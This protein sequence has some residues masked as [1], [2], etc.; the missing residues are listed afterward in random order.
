MS[1]LCPVKFDPRKAYSSC[2]TIHQWNPSPYPWNSSQHHTSPKQP[3]IC[4]PHVYINGSHSSHNS[5]SSSSY[6]SLKWPFNDSSVTLQNENDPKHEPYALYPMSETTSQP[7]SLSYD[8]LHISHTSLTGSNHIPHGYPYEITSHNPH[9]TGKYKKNPPHYKSCAV[10]PNY[11]SKILLSQE[12]PSKFPSAINY[13]S[14]CIPTSIPSEPI[15]THCRFSLTSQNLHTPI[16]S[17]SL[18]TPLNS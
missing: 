6:S 17:E 2:H 16:I 11:P 18:L 15:T 14:P 9:T 4:I 1:I 3:L 13:Y 10:G 7:S 5:P 8:T 12:I